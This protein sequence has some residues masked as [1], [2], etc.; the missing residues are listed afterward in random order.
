MRFGVTNDSPV[1]ASL[2]IVNWASG[3]VVGNVTPPLIAPGARV[4][5]VAEVPINMTGWGLYV[6]AGNG[7]GAVVFDGSDVLACTGDV[8][9]E[10]DVSRAGQPSW[11]MLE[12]DWCP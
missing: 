5:V 8:P 12:G 2:K 7:Q 4:Q 1:A 3:A 6:D 10:V 11:Q 9:I